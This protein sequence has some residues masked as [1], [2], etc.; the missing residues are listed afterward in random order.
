VSQQH[1]TAEK[2]REATASEMEQF[3][4][5]LIARMQSCKADQPDMPAAFW[6]YSRIKGKVEG[7]RG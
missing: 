4:R 7:F 2:S 5:V 3:L 1:G 6:E